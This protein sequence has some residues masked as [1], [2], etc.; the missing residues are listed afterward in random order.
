MPDGDPE[1]TTDVLGLE[2]DPDTVYLIA[3]PE[4]AT[5]EQ[6]RFTEMAIREAFDEA[7]AV[8]LAATDLATPDETLTV[9]EL[10]REDLVAAYEAVAD[11]E[12]NDLELPEGVPGR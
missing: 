6:I 3:V 8:V 10:H 2:D 4:P 11:A 12:D 1:N 7:T 5:E 9:G